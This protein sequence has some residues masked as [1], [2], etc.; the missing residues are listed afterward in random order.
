LCLLWCFDIVESLYWSD[1]LLL[2]EAPLDGSKVVSV[3]DELDDG[4][5]GV[6]GRDDD[7]DSGEEFDE[8]PELLNGFLFLLRPLVTLLLAFE[9]SGRE[10]GDTLSVSLLSSPRD[11]DLVCVWVF[12]RFDSRLRL[13]SFLW[14]RFLL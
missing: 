13:S 11:L 8:K 12:C 10:S 14:F 2:L 6:G 1:G 5:E 3:S 7:E 4:E 9:S